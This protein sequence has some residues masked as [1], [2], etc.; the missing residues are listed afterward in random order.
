M[1]NPEI[2][3][4]INSC[5]KFHKTTLPFIIDSAKKSHIPAN[6]I[7]V[8]VGE[9]DDETERLG[10]IY[11]EPGIIKFRANWGQSDTWNLEL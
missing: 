8:V 4:I 6:N 1:N 3:I 5:Q 9:S 7:Y 11:N 10:T 2:A